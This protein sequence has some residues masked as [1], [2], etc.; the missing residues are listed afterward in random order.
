MIASMN[1][2]MNVLIVDDEPLAREGLALLLRDETGI[3]SVSEARNG[4]EAVEKIVAARPDLVL[5]VSMCCARS[6]PSGCRR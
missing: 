6:A 5:L 3:G 1:G 4:A 2:A